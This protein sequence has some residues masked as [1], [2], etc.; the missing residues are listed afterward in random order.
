MINKD[1]PLKLYQS[2]LR[3]QL[4][5]GTRIL[6]P[7][8][9]KHKAAEPLRTG[10]LATFGHNPVKNGAVALRICYRSEFIFWR[11]CARIFPPSQ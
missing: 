10:S 1:Q 7:Q 6:I 11:A 5:G 9:Q 4:N 8:I 3:V 2:G